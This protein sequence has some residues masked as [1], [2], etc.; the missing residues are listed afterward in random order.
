VFVTNNAPAGDWTLVVVPWPAADPTP[1][2]SRIATHPTNRNVVA[3]AT[4]GLQGRVMLTYNR[5]T[6]WLDITAPV[7][8]VANQDLPPCPITSLAFDPGNTRD[9]YAGTLAGVYTLRNL[10]AQPAGGA[11]IAAFPIDW[12]PFKT[13]LPVVLVQDLAFLP[14]T[15]VLRI[16]TFGRSMYDCDV[17]G[18]PQHRLFIR[19]LLTEDGR[20]AARPAALPFGGFDPRLPAPPSPAAVALDMTHAFDVRVD[21]PPFSFFEEVMDGVEFDEDLASDTLVPGEV[22]VVY[23]QVHNRGF[24]PVR[25]VT[26]HLYFR[27]S[28]AVAFGGA[29][30]ALGNPA[31]VWRPAQGF[32]PVAGSPWQRVGRAQTLPEAGPARPAVAR[33]DWTPPANL[34]G[35][36]VALLALCSGPAG[37]APPAADPLPNAVPGGAAT[38]AALL[39]NER[40]AALRIVPVGPF[41]PEIFIRHG[42][43]DDGTP[44]AVA[45]GGR[46]PDIIVVQS[47]PAQA[48]EVEFQDPGDPRPGDRLK[49]GVKNLIY[50]RVHNR[51]NLP[52]DADVEVLFAKTT[53]PLS[54]AADPAAPPYDPAKWQQIAPVATAT[55]PVPAR[56]WS[57]ALLEWNNPPDPDPGDP[58]PYRAYL[59]VA[60]IKSHDNA[61]PVPVRTRVDSTTFWSFFRVLA[62]SRKAAIRA[63]RYEP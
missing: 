7:P 1:R 31:D 45:F 4:A 26:V 3:V 38:I 6:N 55:I 52:I 32:D 39:T 40:R 9:L 57:L 44:G 62:D 20:A 60:L 42:L 25:N 24:D 22:N 46:S 8:A 18:G 27:P 19:Q 14:G 5:G 58:N 53:V 33:F 51:K 21:A 16:A 23:V 61:D 59:L 30:P 34:A 37:P 36:N 2:V 49:G 50:V 54:A 56:G 10:P 29:V 11:V 41:Q 35:G 17:V 63:V 48:P 43:E 12:R 15:R 28:P 13:R 47:V